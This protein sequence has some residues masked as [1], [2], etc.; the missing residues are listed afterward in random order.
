MRPLL[1][2]MLACSLLAGCGARS[3]SPSGNYDPFENAAAMSTSDIAFLIDNA[4]PSI[5]ARAAYFLG[6][7][8][9]DAAQV[10]P[11][12]MV[13]LRDKNVEVRRAAAASL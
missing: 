6:E 12:L 9:A 11:L 7:R 13:A 3:D 4:D 10:V 5:R 1:C 2:V 8:E